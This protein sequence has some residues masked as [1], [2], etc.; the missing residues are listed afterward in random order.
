MSQYQS[1]PK[2]ATVAAS[3]ERGYTFSRYG[4]SIHSGNAKMKV[5]PN[6]LMRR[7]APGYSSHPEAK[8]IANGR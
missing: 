4:L 3:Q 6:P 1:R 8:T 7:L 2:R 5:W